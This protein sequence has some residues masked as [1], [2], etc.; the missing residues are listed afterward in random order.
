MKLQKIFLTCLIATAFAA[1]SQDDA[2]SS[3]S[4]GDQGDGGITIG[5]DSEIEIRLSQ[6]NLTRASIETD[7][8]GLFN[9]NGVG[10]FML[11]TDI[12]ASNREAHP[13]SWDPAEN[14]F[15][16][17]LNNVQAN[18]VADSPSSSNNVVWAN[19]EHYFYPITNWYAY[20]FY[21][22]YP[23]LDDEDVDVSSTQ[24]VAH[25]TD[26]DGK[27]DVIWGQSLRSIQN[28][29]EVGYETERY[30]YS[31]RYFRQAGKANSLPSIAFEHKLM[32]FQFYIQGIADANAEEGHEYDTA[33]TMMID[34][35]YAVNVP[36]TADLI[37]A[38]FNSPSND[39]TFTVNWNGDKDTLFV[40]GE[41]DGEFQKQQVNGATKIPVGQ[42]LLMPVPSADQLAA[43]FKFQIVVTLRD[44]AGNFFK[45][46]YPI[47]LN[48]TGNYAAGKTYNI[49]IGIAGPK[50][51]SAKATLRA[52]ED[53]E[54]EDGVTIDDLILN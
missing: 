49:V 32:R 44:T 6:S 24:R 42:A 11:A 35:I 26:L 7:E 12:T 16:V 34:S 31:A 2:S 45:G 5:A 23:R 8:N 13:I 54:T 39:G 19:N 40:V 41:N 25:F 48:P 1:C 22:Y 9:A 47:D 17:K 33:N 53:A 3:S 38:D 46:A 30:R 27:K 21:G 52:W 14:Q 36:T 18:I 10:I 50:I 20:R 43:G 37:I 15:A 29:E 28:P 4:L 51:V